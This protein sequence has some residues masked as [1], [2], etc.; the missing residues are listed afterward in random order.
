[1]T[2]PTFT[3]LDEARRGENPTVIG[4]LPSG[5]AVLGDTQFLPGYSILFADPVVESLNT[6]RGAARAQFLGDLVLLGDAIL[7]ATD[8]L[9]INYSVLGNLLP[10]LHG[11][12]FPRYAWEAEGSRKSPVWLYP[13]E[14]R[15]R[16]GFD[17]VRDAPLMKRIHDELQGVGA[18]VDERPYPWQCHV[19]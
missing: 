4:R 7:A 12:A 3:R 19:S 5:W 11:H 8:A 13:A 6:I 14:E 17:L 9:R 18:Q 16:P 15:D 10:I 2:T 1:M